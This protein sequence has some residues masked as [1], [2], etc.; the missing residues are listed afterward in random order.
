MSN[1]ELRF[2]DILNT[3]HLLVLNLRPQRVV[4]SYINSSSLFANLGNRQ[5]V[6]PE[7]R[8]YGLEAIRSDRTQCVRIGQE[9]SEP[10][11]VAHG[12]PQGLIL[13][14]AHLHKR[15]SKRPSPFLPEELS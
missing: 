13:G 14:P 8:S 2:R 15:S 10:R 6:L 12:V 4:E 1:E 9:V 11:E 3:L 7:K 5:Q